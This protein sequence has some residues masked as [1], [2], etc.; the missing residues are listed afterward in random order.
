MVVQDSPEFNFCSTDET[1]PV[2]DPGAKI[3]FFQACH[4][5]AEI[6]VKSGIRPK[7]HHAEASRHTCRIGL[8]SDH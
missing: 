4:Q 5:A 6:L 2:V 1:G 8:K 3:C 7:T